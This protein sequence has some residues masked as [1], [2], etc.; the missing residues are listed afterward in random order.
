[1]RLSVCLGGHTY[2]FRDVRDVMGKAN[3]EKSGDQLCG[4]AAQT[5]QERVAARIVLSEMTV[6]E[7]CE[8]PAVPYE[9]DEVTRLILDGLNL[10][11]YREY[12]NMTIGELRERILSAPPE[13]LTR[14]GRGLSSEVIAAVCKLMSN[15]DLIYAAARMRV[16]ATCVT[17][18][19]EPGTLSARLQPNHPVDDVEGITASVL[20]GLS[21]GIGDAVIGLNPGDASTASVQAILTRFDEL[22]RR[23]EI[24]T[25]ICVLAH[26]TTQM[27]AVRNGAPC[28]LMF[29]SIAGSEKGN[30]AFGIS[31]ELIAEAKDLMARE[32]PSHGPN[33]L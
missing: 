28:D 20:E 19:G 24:P 31:A 1:M 23:S 9:Q 5:P 13:E 25:Q 7:I 29:Q 27:E 16:K 33:Q 14:M 26:V 2:S 12:Q 18:I 8:H 30:A 17:T 21:F 32:G 10:P 15:L 3:E 6:K 22:K 11:I 4:V